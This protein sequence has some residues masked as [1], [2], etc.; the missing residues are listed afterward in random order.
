MKAGSGYLIGTAGHVLL[1]ASFQPL[2]HFRSDS[3]TRLVLHGIA[4]FVIWPYAS[5]LTRLYVN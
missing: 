4:A 2:D 1:N 3:F 5:M